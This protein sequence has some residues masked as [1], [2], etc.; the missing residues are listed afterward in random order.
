[1]TRYFNIK[2]DISAYHD[3]FYSQIASIFLR[4]T[5]DGLKML[6]LLVKIVNGNAIRFRDSCATKKDIISLFCHFAESRNLGV[7]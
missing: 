1:M 5:F 6:F 4:F 3:I 7:A 2:H